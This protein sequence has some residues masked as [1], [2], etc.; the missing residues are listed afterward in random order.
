MWLKK[1]LFFYTTE[2][3]TVDPI[4]AYELPKA[5]RHSFI[6]DGSE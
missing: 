4:D 2:E 5:F 3:S 6:E 1:R